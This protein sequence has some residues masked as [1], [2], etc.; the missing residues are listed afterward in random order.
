MLQV[1]SGKFYRLGGDIT[2][3]AAEGV[4]YSN[5]AYP[6]PIVTSI[7]TL[8]LVDAD[9][10]IGKY[11]MSYVARFEQRPK[12]LRILRMGDSTIVEQLRLLALFSFKAYFATARSQVMTTCQRVEGTDAR[13]HPASYVRTFLDPVVEL[14]PDKVEQFRHFVDKVIAMPRKSYEKVMDCL[15]CFADALELVAYNMDLAYSMLVYCAEA[16]SQGFDNFVAGW[17]D[18]P[19]DSRVPLNTIFAGIDPTAADGIKKVLLGQQHFKLTQRFTN[20]LSN[21]LPESFY[22]NDADG[23]VNPI[24][25]SELK[26]LL[27]NIYGARSKFVHE[28]NGVR[29]QIKVS[30]IGNGEVFHT[31]GDPY[32][33]FNGMVRLVHTAINEFIARQPVLDTENFEWDWAL[34]KILPTDVV[35]LPP[36]P[37][38]WIW[39]VGSAVPQLSA[40]RLTGFLSSLLTREMTDMN[41]VVEKYI[42]SLP[43]VQSE[44]DRLHMALL[45]ELYFYVYG[46]MPGVGDLKEK[47]APSGSRLNKP[48]IHA[49]LYRLLTG[50]D[51]SW[52]ADRSAEMYTT[53]EKQRVS[54][55]FSIP[56]VWEL[57]LMLEVANQFNGASNDAKCAAWKKKAR[58]EATGNLALQTDIA[59][60]LSAGGKFHLNGLFQFDIAA[61]NR[62]LVEDR[63]FFISLRRKSSGGIGDDLSDWLEAEA[64]VFEMETQET[65]RQRATDSGAP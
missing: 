4:V 61:E 49:M 59:S 32:L 55:E 64:E 33:T 34:S 57:A 18:V 45:C 56:L 48:S 7:A 12:R 44:K 51:W 28:L 23:L 62:H 26:K 24:R 20:F 35:E 63:A 30:Q 54:G 11:S 17:D 38:H 53:Y 6:L 8:V 65:M 46:Q 25:P 5:T 2:E 3:T 40:R 9:D 31:S 22:T 15:G 21:H 39:E 52:P 27:L 58:L 13:N 41:A 47:Y 60:S 43:E 37:K 16:L 1:I 50:A 29:N 19:E 14:T 42:T 10:G 36:A